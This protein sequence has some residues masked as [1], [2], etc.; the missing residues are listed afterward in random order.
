MGL[1][2]RGFAMLR[3]VN[4][5]GLV[6]VVSFSVILG[7]ALFATGASQVAGYIPGSFTVNELNGAAEYTI[8]IKTPVGIKGIEPHLSL[9]YSSQSGN[10]LLGVGWS[11]A[12][13]PVITRKSTVA[14]RDG[15]THSVDYTANDRFALNGNTL[16]CVSGTYGADGAVYRSERDEFSKIVSYGTAG[17]GPSYFKVWTKDGKIMEFGNTTDSKVKAYD[18]QDVAVWAMNRLQD[19]CGNYMTVAYHYESLSF[20]YVKYWID[21]ISYAYVSGQ[22]KCS[23]SFEYDTVRQD[24]IVTYA[25]SFAT[26]IDFRLIKIKT[27]AGSD[28]VKSYSFGYEYAGAVQRSRLVTITEYKGQTYQLPTTAITYKTN[29]LGLQRQIWGN[30]A[31]GYDLSNA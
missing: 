19:L 9:K 11:L 27:Y 30:L 7:Y 4:V 23:V 17:A 6:C 2:M 1:N 31:A 5:L 25:N 22:A 28:N 15:I 18:R 3:R 8:P 29:T 14:M 10:G 24:P 20:G 21:T 16:I 13:I 26:K 12:G